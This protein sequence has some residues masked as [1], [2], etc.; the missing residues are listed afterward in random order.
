MSETDNDEYIDN[1]KD[2]REIILKLSSSNQVKICQKWLKRFN[3]ASLKERT[4]RNRLL[5]LMCEQLEANKL[6]LP[7][8]CMD[9]LKKPLYDLHPRTFDVGGGH[10]DHEHYNFI[11]QFTNE[12]FLKSLNDYFQQY[13]VL[14]TEF[15]FFSR[16]FATFP[17]GSVRQGM[18]NFDRGIN[19]FLKNVTTKISVELESFYEQK[20][21]E[22]ERKLE[23]QTE[24][25]QRIET[26]MTDCK[27]SEMTSSLISQETQT[28][29]NLFEN[30]KKI[31]K[32]LRKLKTR[33]EM[34][35][36]ELRETNLNQYRAYRIQLAIQ[37]G[38]ILLETGAKHQQDLIESTNN[39]ESVFNRLIN[40]I[41]HRFSS[42]L[43]SLLSC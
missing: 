43:S 35:V 11:D 40:E 37:K 21:I 15:S 4:S 8:I 3:N 38:E 23:E 9:N 27:N 25:V 32:I 28:D 19:N 14:N 5:S 34:K 33:Y 1:L 7:F 17:E 29:E 36:N 42:S 12:L 18:I 24:N 41:Q 26:A 30:R 39:Y 20:F 22:L 13:D 2:L 31:E 10:G 6:G 16:M